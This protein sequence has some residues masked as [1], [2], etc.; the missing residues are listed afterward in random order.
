MHHVLD[1]LALGAE[2]DFDTPAF[3]VLK[4]HIELNKFTHHVLDEAEPIFH[5]E[6][7]AN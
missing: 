4:E 1:D 3:N 7:L 2:Y 5:R 6:K